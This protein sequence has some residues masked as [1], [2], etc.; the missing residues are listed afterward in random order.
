MDRTYLKSKSKQ[1]LKENLVISI[2]T[3]F[4]ASIFI[5]A[6]TLKNGV[7]FFYGDGSYIYLDLLTI[8]FAGVFTTGLNKFLLKI[9]KNS[10]TP[11]IGDLFSHFNIYLKT[12]GLYVVI[13]VIGFIGTLLFII[14]GIILLIMFSQ[15]FFILAEDPSKSIKDCMVESQ[16]MMYGHKSEYFVLQLSFI[17]WYLLTG[18][19]LGIAGFWVN[20]YVKITNANYYLEIK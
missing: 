18:I 11:E 16:K 3:V 2:I 9:V 1:Q 4:I 7:T 12:L 15:S 13:A 17:G 6:S 20:P 14:P 8:L 10:S 5:D 19:T